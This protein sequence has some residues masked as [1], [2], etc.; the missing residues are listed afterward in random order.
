M[1][2]RCTSVQNDNWR[3]FVLKFWKKKE[4]WWAQG[5][6]G[7]DKDGSGNHASISSRGKL[8]LSTADIQSQDF[9]NLCEPVDFSEQ[10][11]ILLIF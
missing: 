11:T 8:T 9:F 7:N 10:I 1:E 3:V 5:S 4:H 2:I 6:E